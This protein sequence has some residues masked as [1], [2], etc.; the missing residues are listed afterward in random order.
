M[1]GGPDPGLLSRSRGRVYFEE[2][3]AFS[4]QF[5]QVLPFSF[6]VPSCSQP[7][8]QGFF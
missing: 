4:T 2:E 6:S 8:Q 5:S 3:L 7:F 1:R